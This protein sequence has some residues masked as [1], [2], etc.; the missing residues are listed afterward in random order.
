MCWVTDNDAEGDS[1]SVTEF[2]VAGVSG[3]T[4]A[5]GNTAT[6]PGVGTLLV[7]TNGDFTFTPETG[8]TGAVPTATYTASDGNGGTDTGDL[9]FNDIVNGLSVA[10]DTAL[11]FTGGDTVTVPAAA[12]DVNTVQLSVNNGTLDVDLTGG[13]TISVGVDNS[14]TLTLSGTETENQC[15]TRNTSVPG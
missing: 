1:L 2:T 3:L 7:E 10:E 14:P 13:A 9:S 8:Y 15:S 12:V 5:G 6:I 4:F 11:S